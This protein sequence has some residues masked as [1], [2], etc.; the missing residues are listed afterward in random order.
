MPKILVIADD[1][2]GALDTGVQFCRAGAR[3]IV[4]TAAFAV[5]KIFK[6][7]D[8]N[9]KTSCTGK[10]MGAPTEDSGDCTYGKQTF[11]KTSGCTYENEVSGGIESTVP[12]EIPKKTN[13]YIDIDDYCVL[14]IDTE[15]RHMP[16]AAAARLVKTLVRAAVR[17]GYSFFYKK[18][19]S[20]LRGNIGAELE[21]LLTSCGAC[22]LSFAPAFPK[23]GR[24]TAGG[25]H[26]IDGK[27]LGESVFAC[28]P[29]EPVKHSDVKS[30][31][32]EQTEIPIYH[33]NVYY[34]HD[35]TRIENTEKHYIDKIRGRDSGL[36]RGEDWIYEGDGGIYQGDC[37]SSDK[38][39]GC[40]GSHKI[41]IYDAESDDDLLLLGRYLKSHGKLRCLAGCAGFAAVLP[42]LYEIGNNAAQRKTNNVNIATD[43][44]DVNA[45]IDTDD[46][47]VNA[48]NKSDGIE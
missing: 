28:D 16:P 26:Y 25:I 20:A 17:L 12:V 30:I 10:L 32:A 38:Y 5:F 4:T 9:T 43:D 48:Y 7:P 33:Y 8:E 35:N 14:A 34:Y 15:T 31:L 36:Y 42:E 1:Y 41:E 11:V 23:S 27:P 46:F 22:T 21:A 3:V 2:T 39:I 6:M 13:V 44:F 19:D 47:D 45:N 37:E 18:T 24:I 29:S 40:D